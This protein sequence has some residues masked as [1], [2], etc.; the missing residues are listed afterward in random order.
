MGVDNGDH[1][2]HCV[3]GVPTLHLKATARSWLDFFLLL[4]DDEETEL[5]VRKSVVLF[6]LPGRRVL[7][8]AASSRF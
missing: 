2:L 4:D 8:H 7:N 3:Q 6:H 5:F 1:A